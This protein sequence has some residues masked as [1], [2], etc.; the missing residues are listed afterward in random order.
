MTE[1]EKQGFG[2]LCT[3]TVNITLKLRRKKQFQK[4][5]KTGRDNE[6]QKRK[7]IKG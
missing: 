5:I 1:N 3:Y 4:R 2:Y 7:I 6:T